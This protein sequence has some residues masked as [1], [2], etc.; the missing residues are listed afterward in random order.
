MAKGYESTKTRITMTTSVANPTTGIVTLS[1]TASSNA[2]LD[3][4]ICL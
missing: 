2:A 3:A 4:P 1:L